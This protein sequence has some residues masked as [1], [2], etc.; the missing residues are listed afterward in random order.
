M[1]LRTTAFKNA[2]EFSVADNIIP[3]CELAK[4]LAEAGEFDTAYETLQSFWQGPLHRPDTAGLPDDAKAELLLRTGTLTGWLG[5][6]RQIAGANEVA[7]DLISESVHIFDRLGSPEKVAEAQV[8]L[9]LCYW[10]EGALDEARVTLRLVLDS[11]EGVQ[12]E[13]KLRALLNIAIVEKVATRDQESLKIYREAAPQFE[14]S[15]NHALKG[16][17]HNAYATLLK[18]LGLS[19][20]REEYVDLAL[21]EFAAA[22]F[23]FEQAGFPR[24][25]APV[26]NNVGFLFGSLGRFDEATQHVKNARAL[27]LKLS[28]H[29]GAAYADDTLAQV[30]LMQGRSEDAE[31]VA[32]R[33]VQTLKRGGEQTVLAEA[34]TTHGKALARLKQ[35][36]V[37][38]AALDQAVEIAEIAG[39]P[40]RGGIAAVTAIEE[41]SDNLSIDVLQNY[42]RTAESLLA[43]SQNTSIRTRLGECARRVLSAALDTADEA[44]PAATDAVDLT[45][46]FSLDSEVLRYEGN[47]IRRALEESGGSVTRAARLLGVTHQ[48]LAFI[49][50]GRHSDLLSIRTPVKRR[51]RSIIRNH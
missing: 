27:W 28:D 17:F 48:G 46:G 33:A 13:Q 9:A 45:P 32:H 8:D 24:F 44:T 36:D 10:R 50:N 34:L 31:R 19:E 12:S 43:K 18:T 20:K 25:Q 38:R 40:D 1:D 37:A 29:G 51:R 4:N 30:Y 23:H 22:S 2:T 16:K 26:E 47:L 14:L 42:Y 35:I 41:L 7:K 11:L 15:N 3:L 39:N 49:L 6:T 21:V 5:S